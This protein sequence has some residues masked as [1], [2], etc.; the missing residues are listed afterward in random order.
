MA[1][2][3]PTSRITALVV[4]TALLMWSLGTTYR[5]GDAGVAAAS[6]AALLV[7]YVAGRCVTQRTTTSPE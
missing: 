3:D 7:W 2:L 6:A 5:A 4:N 1:P